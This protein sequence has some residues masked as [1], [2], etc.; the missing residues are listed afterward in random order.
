M[1]KGLESVPDHV[2]KVVKIMRQNDV[3]LKEYIE[4]MSPSLKYLEKNKIPDEASDVVRKNSANFLKKETLFMYRLYAKMDLSSQ[5]KETGSAILMKSYNLIH[6]LN[7]LT[8]TLA[9]D[10]EDGVCVQQVTFDISKCIVNRLESCVKEYEQLPSVQL[11]RLAQKSPG[12]T[13]RLKWFAQGKPRTD[14]YDF[15]GID[16]EKYVPKK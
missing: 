8:N 12:I 7:F 16:V 9:E 3:P 5:T 10:I 2:A 1:I 6:R 11:Y 14:T 13:S 4:M 15:T